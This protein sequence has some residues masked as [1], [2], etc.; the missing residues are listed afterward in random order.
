MRH[1][2]FIDTMRSWAA[3]RSWRSVDRTVRTPVQKFKVME[4]GFVQFYIDG[5]R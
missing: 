4:K 2:L 3:C 1:L 5:I